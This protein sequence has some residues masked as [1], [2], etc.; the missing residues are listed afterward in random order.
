MVK[1]RQGFVSNSSSSSFCIAKCYM[2]DDQIAKFKKLMSEKFDDWQDDP[3]REFKNGTSENGNYFM[4][5]YEDHGDGI[6]EVINLLK[7]KDY[8]MGSL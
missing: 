2:T 8:F 7:L 6:T 5:Y 3:L 4:G 1:I